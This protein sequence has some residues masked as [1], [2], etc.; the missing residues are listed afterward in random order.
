LQGRRLIPTAYAYDVIL[1]GDNG[2]AVQKNT[3]TLVDAS[4]GIVLEVNTGKTKYV[5]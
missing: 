2:N 5:L 4:K 3:E 1:L